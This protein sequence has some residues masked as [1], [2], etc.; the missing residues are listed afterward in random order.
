MTDYQ[1]HLRSLPDEALI[2]AALLCWE[3]CTK[4]LDR[5][6]L[7]KEGWDDIAAELKSPR[8]PSDLWD[9]ATITFHLQRAQRRK[10]NTMTPRE[11]L[12]YYARKDQE[13]QSGEAT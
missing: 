2:H 7:T 5:D 6:A 10:I 4:S 1:Q 11:T 8:R 9:K 12:D 13:K 3:R